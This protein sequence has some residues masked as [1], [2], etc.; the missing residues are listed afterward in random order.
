MI[1]LAHYQGIGQFGRAY[2]VMLERDAHASGSVDRVLAEQMIRLCAETADYLY[3]DYSPTKV[4]YVP[5]SRPALDRV[6]RDALL[7]CYEDET[8]IEAIARFCAAMGRRAPSGLDA[9]RL[10]GTEEQILERGSDWCTDVA[11]V[12]CVLAQIA[13]YPARLVNLFDLDKAYSGH[14]IVEVFREGAWGAVDATT[15]VVYRHPISRPATTWEL[16]AFPRLIAEN[17]EE[18][19]GF[20]TRVGQFSAAGIVNY[21]VADQARYDYT[22]SAPNDT[23]RAILAESS[24]G[25]PGGLRWL[26][27]EGEA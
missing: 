19:H 11:R 12:G 2:G 16:M 17:A 4:E 6:V 15:G 26:F 10:G 25:W 9:L 7:D 20:Y 5:N 8:R 24:R 21:P 27:G 18:T 13:G 1:D 22:I 14:V 3:A 23:L